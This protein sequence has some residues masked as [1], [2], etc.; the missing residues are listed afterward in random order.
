MNRGLGVMRRDCYRLDLVC[1]A[2]VHWGPPGETIEV[3]MGSCDGH[4]AFWRVLLMMLGDAMRIGGS[5]LRVARH[6]LRLVMAST[7]ESFV[8][9]CVFVGVHV[10]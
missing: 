2:V 9:C 5:C 1:A 4:D 6:V 10:C 3:V 7:V 8:S